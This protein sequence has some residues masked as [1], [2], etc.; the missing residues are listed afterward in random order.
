LDGRYKIFGDF[1]VD[2]GFQ[3]REPDLSQR[4]V[5]VLLCQHAFTSEIL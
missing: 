3:Q 5:D 4:G 2:V 1:I